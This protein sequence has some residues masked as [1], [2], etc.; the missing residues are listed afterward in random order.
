MV[1]TTL[2][3]ST[4][5]YTNQINT[6]GNFVQTFQ[7]GANLL[8]VDA[9]D[10]TKKFQ[11][12][13]SNIATSTTRTVNIPNANSTTVQA[14]TASAHQFATA[15]SAQGVVA[16][17]QPA[18]TD[19]SGTIAAGQIATG[20]VTWDTLGNAAGALT[21]ANGTN[22]TTFNQTAA[23]NWTWANTTAATAAGAT[24]SSPILNL[25]GKFFSSGVDTADT[26]S[27]KTVIAAAKSFAISN[28]SETVGNVVT[29]TISGGT[30]VAGETVTFTGLTTG[31]WLNSQNATLTTASATTLTFTDP[32]SHGTQASHAETGT[33]TQQNPL[34]QLVISHSGTPVPSATANVLGP[35]VV[36]PGWAGAT[37]PNLLS[38]NSNTIGLLVSDSIG[39]ALSIFSTGS[40]IRFYESTT[41]KAPI[42]GVT[43]Q[44]TAK[45]MSFGTFNNSGYTT[46][47]LGPLDNPATSLVPTLTFR[48]NN[49]ITAGFSSTSSNITGVTFGSIDGVIPVTGGNVV[50]GTITWS[51][52]SGTTAFTAV[53]INPIINQTSITGTIGGIEVASNV[54]TVAFTTVLGTAMTSGATTVTVTAGTNTSIN[55]SGN[56][57][58]TSVNRTTVNVTNSSETAG[59]AVTLTVG[60]HAIVAND[61]CYI[62]GLTV[63]TWLN[64]KVVKITSVV[65]NSTITFPDPTSHGTSAS[66]PEGGGSVVTSYIKY[67]K[68][69]GNITLT[70]DTGSAVQQATGNYTALKVNT[71][72]TLLGGSVTGC[73][74]LDLQINNVS[75]CSMNRQGLITVY[76][77]VATVNNGVPA[78]YAAI[79]LTAQTAAIGATLLYAVPAGAG[80]MYRISWSA[81]VTTVGGSSS[82][83]GGTNGFQVLATSPTDSVVKTFP[84]TSTSGVNTD[85]T[86]TTA[87]GI[88]G[89]IV[90]YAKASTNIQ[91]QMDYTS[92]GSAMAYELHIKCERM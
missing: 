73:N 53:N 86:N 35:A 54:V 27:L 42:G 56:T 11:F 62:S 83:L 75:Q 72:E 59:S 3:P 1:E 19:I 23:T 71:T 45:V 55:G 2:L 7:G 77:G 4:V 5:V 51:P 50:G 90:V 38:S 20:T 18:F 34:S 82:T 31:T 14:S 80:G 37:N 65:A 29:L 16:Y 21:L 68:T 70:T 57:L 85:S 17:G 28:I 30:F 46:T 78:E 60:T 8:I 6:F 44:P 76:G 9:S 87:T 61:Y 25:N 36:L 48:A 58:T 67:S 40:L 26:W 12:D 89:V 66:T 13:V 64:G 84:R 33:V 69:T 15:V 88:S 81:D 43:S 39:I 91:Y 47:C 52:I 32:T 24:S 10:V 92:S 49:S 74:L 63:A 41:T 22:A 79:D